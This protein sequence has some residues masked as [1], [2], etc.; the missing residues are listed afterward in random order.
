MFNKR[1][2]A[3]AHGR[4]SL[5]NGCMKQADLSLDLTHRKAP[6]AMFLDEMDRVVPWAELLALITLHALRKERGR[7]QFDI[8]AM[9]RIHFMQNWFGLSGGAMEEALSDSRSV[10]SLPAWVA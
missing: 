7:P 8:E 9:L 1:P 4:D 6:K 3:L 10:G 5:D 2:A